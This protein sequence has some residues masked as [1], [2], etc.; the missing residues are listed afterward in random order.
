LTGYHF[1]PES[2]LP[3]ARDVDGLK[4]AAL[5]TLQHGLTRDAES[6]DCL[7]HWQE[8]VVGITVESRLEVVGEP[9][10]PGRTGRD[11]L[12][13]DDAVIDETMNGR[14]CDAERGRGTFDGQQFAC[15]GVKSSERSMGSSS[16]SAG[17]IHDSPRSD[18]RAQSCGPAD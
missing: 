15:G 5:D 3:P 7:A 17:C 1:D 8:S 4:L 18:S 10:A 13:S 9:D 11:L 6:A 12:T 2:F 16:A 14:A